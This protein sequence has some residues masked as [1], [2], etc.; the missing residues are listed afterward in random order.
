VLGITYNIGDDG[1]EDV[2]VVVGRATT[3]LGGMMRAQTH[4]IRALARR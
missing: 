2:E 1:Q 3:T 4:D